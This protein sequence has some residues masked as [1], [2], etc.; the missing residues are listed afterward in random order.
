MIPIFCQN[1]S[2]LSFFT[3]IKRRALV[4]LRPTFY[5]KIQRA[6]K[7]VIFSQDLTANVSVYVINRKCHYVM[8]HQWNWRAW[9]SSIPPRVLIGHLKLLI[10]TLI[11]SSRSAR[12]RSSHSFSE[13]QPSGVQKGKPP[14]VA[15]KRGD[16]RR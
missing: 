4:S 3:R 6:N 16:C 2:I 10:R 11:R 7:L 12:R 13:F 1:T 8:S 15:R 5:T 9:K 14:P